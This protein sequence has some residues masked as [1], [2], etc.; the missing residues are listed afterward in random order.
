VNSHQGRYSAQCIDKFPEVGLPSPGN[1]Q[2]N[3]T[4]NSE[5]TKK[6]IGS[7]HFT[8]QQQGVQVGFGLLGW[9]R[10]EHFY[11]GFYHG[12]FG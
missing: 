7:S 10:P 12:S 2:Q 11:H 5:K 1:N 4:Q 9:D 6:E 3:N 8:A